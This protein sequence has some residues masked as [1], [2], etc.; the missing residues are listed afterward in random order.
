M[1]TRENARPLIG[2]YI[3]SRLLI[4]SRDNP[5]LMF[6]SRK[7]YSCSI[8][9]DSSHPPL[10]LAHSSSLTHPSLPSPGRLSLQ[11][12]KRALFNTFSIRFR[13][14]LFDPVQSQPYLHLRPDTD[15]DTPA[16]RMLN[17]QVRGE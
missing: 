9:I 3:N 5:R 4:G 11:Y 2:S 13:L 14:G 15:V 8:L 10:T 17:R 7:R 1:A 12:I 6:G 16:A